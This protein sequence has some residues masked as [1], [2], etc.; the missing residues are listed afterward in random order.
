MTITRTR[1]EIW[2][3]ALMGQV[4]PREMPLG[5]SAAA[6]EG[7]GDRYPL[8]FLSTRRGPALPRREGVPGYSTVS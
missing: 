7:R 2:T 1:V 6:R 4:V 5:G 8:E 3:H